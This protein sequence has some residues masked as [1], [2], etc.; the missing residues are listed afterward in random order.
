MH[1]YTF[2]TYIHSGI[3]NTT[4]KIETVKEGKEE[5]EEEREGV[6][7]AEGEAKPQ[8]E[9]AKLVEEGEEEEEEEGEKDTAESSR[10]PGNVSTPE[11]RSSSVDTTHRDTPESVVITPTIIPDDVPP[12]MVRGRQKH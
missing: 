2:V 4:K 6:F 1:I 11:E 7:E 10:S 9:A 12:N 8:E 3:F 5:E